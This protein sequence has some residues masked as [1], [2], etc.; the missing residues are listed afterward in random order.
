VNPRILQNKCKISL[1]PFIDNT[2]RRLLRV[3]DNTNE[4]RDIDGSPR[5]RPFFPP[6]KLC[7]D[8]G[9]MVAWAGIEQ[10]CKGYSSSVAESPAEAVQPLARWTL[11]P[12]VNRN[13]DVVFRKRV[14]HR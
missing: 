10:F 7:T 5:W 4:M 13:N 12:H 6:P 11:G 8:N 9:V 1:I 14:K 2:I 3:L